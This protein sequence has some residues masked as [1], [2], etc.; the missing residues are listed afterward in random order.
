VA[1]FKRNAGRRLID[2]LSA[3]GIRR[4]LGPPQ[5]YLLTVAGRRS[6][7]PHTTPVS[8]V[9]DGANR[10]L[11]AP[12]GEVGWVRNARESGSVV[13]ERGTRREHCTV[14]PIT[15]SGAGF[16]LKKYL[17]LEPITKPYFRVP[18][19]APVEAFAPE[20]ATHPVFKLGSPG[21]R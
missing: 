5:R 11:V 14:V 4:G 21:Q 12:Y 2:A 10:Y 15:G 1:V 8:V 20:V 3:A 17:A 19:D 7:R 6:G 18:R 16:V 9:S 13:L